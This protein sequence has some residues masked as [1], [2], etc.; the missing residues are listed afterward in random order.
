GI[1]GPS[2][3][4]FPSV[5]ELA[6]HRVHAAAPGAVEQFQ[7]AFG[8]GLA[9]LDDLDQRFEVDALVGAVAVEPGATLQA[10]GGDLQRL[11]GEVAYRA[12]AER[13]FQRLLRH[14][15]AQR[16]A[17]GHGEVLDQV[18]RRVQRLV[19]VEQA[20]PERGQRAQPVP[21]AAVGAAHFQVLLEAHLGEGGGEVVG[22]VLHGRLG[23]GQR[24]E[25][26]G[27]EALEVLAGEVDVPA[28]LVAEVHRYV[29]DVVDVALVA[30]AV[31][32]HEVE[33]A[34]AVGVGVGPDVRAV[35][36]IAVWT[37]F[38][39]R[40]IG[41]QRGGDRL[42]REAGAE[43]LDHVRFGR[44]IQVHL[45]GAGARH[46]VQ[47]E[48]ADLG[49]VFAHDL[50]A[51]L[52]HP[53]H[54]VAP[55]LRLEAH[56]EETQAHAVGHRAHF[57]QMRIHLA[58]GLVDGFQRRAG[59]LQLAGRFQ[60]DIRLVAGERDRNIAFAGDLPAVTCGDAFQ[61]RPD[62]ALAL[63]RRSAQ[64]VGAEAELLVLGADAP[65]LARLLA[66][67]EVVDQLLAPGDGRALDG[68]GYGHGH[69]LAG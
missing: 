12:V 65:S 59:E 21:R 40:R 4:W 17:L 27:H 64:V 52:G 53:R 7:L 39:E 6:E 51:A 60:R 35:G 11:A 48:R 22:P 66:R 9:R 68:T 32:E 10:V 3:W 25:F 50:V 31:G 24:G 38:R 61:Q 1:A 33:H 13:Q 8:R 69:G 54:L 20:D 5:R 62:A 56:A 49:H 58:A 57:L 63:E 23:A 19:V 16:M 44:E 2:S 67:G 18:P 46:H 55:P 15:V 29:E 26:A 36:Q 41:E 45:H 14:V 37:S 43:F 42:Q 34:G 47:A 28:V 30:E